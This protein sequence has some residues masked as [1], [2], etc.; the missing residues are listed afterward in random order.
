MRVLSQKSN[1]FPRSVFSQSLPR[2]LNRRH[3]LRQL[4][5]SQKFLS[6]QDIVVSAA[7]PVSPS[8]AEV[9]GKVRL[10]RFWRRLRTRVAAW[11]S[12]R[13]APRVR[14]ELHAE[15]YMNI[16][17]ATPARERQGSSRRDSSPASD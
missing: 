8:Q 13:S 7:A 4:E 2:S 3:P 11:H 17:K 1:L 16:K 15:T 14:L 5:R 12:R 10:G 9:P 6:M